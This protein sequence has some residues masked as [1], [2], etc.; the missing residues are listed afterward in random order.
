MIVFLG[1]PIASWGDPQISLR[2]DSF[3]AERVSREPG[4]ERVRFE[5]S[6]FGHDRSGPP[7]ESSFPSLA[8]REVQE[9]PYLILTGAGQ[10]DERRHQRNG[11]G[12]IRTDREEATPQVHGDGC[13][14]VTGGPE[15]CGQGPLERRVSEVGPLL[16]QRSQLAL[17]TVACTTEVRPDRKEVHM[18]TKNTVVEAA[19]AVAETAPIDPTELVPLAQLCVEGFGYSHP[20]VVTPRDAVDAL[21]AQLD[22]E[23]VLDDLGRRCVSREAARRLFTERAEAERR[24]REAQQRHEEELAEQA[25]NNRPRGGI[26]AD[27][28]PDGVSPAAAMLQAARGAEPR[29][30]TPLEEAFDNDGAL[31]FHSLSEES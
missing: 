23:V 14:N 8:L 27:R 7:R 22:G 2:P 6:V 18:F 5:M 13:V 19:E 31:T 15:A 16:V 3:C 26:P 20:L 24:Q 10:R 4:R 9:H 21:A 11:V 29:R 28:I 1:G 30:R 12:G 17:R 25:A